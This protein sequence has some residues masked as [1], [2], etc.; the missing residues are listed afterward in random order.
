VPAV[1]IAVT[2]MFCVQLG[3]AASTGLFS[4]V[5]PAGTAWL[6]L[7]WAAVIFV[8]IARPRPWKM[9]RRDLGTAIM[10]GIV[11]AGMTLLFFEAIARIALGTAVAIEFLGPL[12]VA[13]LRRSGRWGLLWPALAGTGVLLVTRPWEGTVQGAGIA[14][15]LGTA[16]CW[17]GYIL[18]TQQV[19]DRLEGL[20]G[21]AISMPAAAL[22]ATIVAAPGTWS[23]VTLG[24]IVIAAGLALLLPVLPYALELQALRRLPAG[25]FGTIM[26]AEPAIA[27][28]IGLAVLGQVPGLLQT[29]GVLLVTLAAAGVARA[30]QPEQEDGAPEEAVVGVGS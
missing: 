24:S 30:G 20:D 11:S 15:A 7:C 4:R 18:L 8:V 2:S 16:G 17:A 19:G 3:A 27:L 9:A 6:R 28:L 26:A 13:V 23:R 21:L 29:L 1:A 25:V 14:F 5:G 12:M 22:T 10:L